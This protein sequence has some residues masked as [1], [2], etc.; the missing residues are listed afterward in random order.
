MIIAWYESKN[1][2]STDFQTKYKCYSSNN[3]AIM[4]IGFF[5]FQKFDFSSKIKASYVPCYQLAGLSQKDYMLKDNLPITAMAEYE[6]CLFMGTINGQILIVDSQTF[7]K[8]QTD[9]KYYARS[10]II[11]DNPINKLEVRENDLIVGS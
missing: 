10:Y 2:A 7:A 8:R 3:G 6:G 9:N 11:T 4:S 1:E 5:Q